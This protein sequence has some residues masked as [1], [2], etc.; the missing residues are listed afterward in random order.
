MLVGADPDSIHV[1]AFD[2]RGFG[3]STG[4]PTEEG[5]VK[6]GIAAVDWALQVAGVPPDRIVLCGQ[7]LGTAVATSVA[8]HYAVEKQIGFAGL[9]LVAPFSSIP[10][11]L[12]RYFIAGFIP[13]LS[14]LRTYPLV[15]SWVLSKVVDKW[16]TTA[17]LANLVG[18]SESLNVVLIHARNDAEIPSSH[19]EDLFIA[20]ANATAKDGM[21]Y[22]TISDVRQ[23]E[24]MIG[25]GW[26]DTWIA[27][28]ADHIIKRIKLVMAPYGG[29]FSIISS[30]SGLTW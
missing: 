25:G 22:K 16:N 19:S 30:S 1:L 27:E 21:D 24:D 26:E 11:L 10:D 5:L 28:G 12:P 9:V 18:H 17:R 13:T 7:S 20:A 14:P 3:Y 2:Y 23:H 8:E 15:L 29:R 4:S 6:D